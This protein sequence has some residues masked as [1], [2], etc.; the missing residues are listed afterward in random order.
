MRNK[1]FEEW[2]SLGH[3]YSKESQLESF[4]RSEG[5]YSEYLLGNV[6]DFLEESFLAGMREEFNIEASQVF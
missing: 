2:V 5:I 4:L 6:L 1:H 3:P